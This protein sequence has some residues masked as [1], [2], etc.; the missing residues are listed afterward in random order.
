MSKKTPA[1][2]GLRPPDPLLALPH[3]RTP[4]CVESK[5]SLKLSYVSIPIRSWEF[6][7]ARDAGCKR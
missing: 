2:G 3:W 4:P 6:L 7:A 1:S 5:K